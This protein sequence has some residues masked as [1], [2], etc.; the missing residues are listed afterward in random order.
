MNPVLE[1]LSDG[2]IGVRLRAVDLLLHIRQVDPAAPESPDNLENRLTTPTLCGAR[3]HPNS[4]DN[5]RMTFA[6]EIMGGT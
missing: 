1:L 2:V 3:K 4:T 6:C 5:F